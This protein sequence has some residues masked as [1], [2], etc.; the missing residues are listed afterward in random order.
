MSTKLGTLT[1]DLVAKIGNFVE[2]MNQAEKK[3]KG[4]SQT[5]AEGFNVSTLA[6]NALG[7]A[8]AGVTVGGLAA[9]TNQVIRVC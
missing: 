7:A 9:F 3:A 4:T 1:L 2:P 5:I 8:F 6:V